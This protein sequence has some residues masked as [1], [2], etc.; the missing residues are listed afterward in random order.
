[1]IVGDSER[2]TAWVVLE[3][4]RDLIRADAIVSITAVPAEG[5]I[6][7]ADWARTHPSKRLHPSRPA[8]V[9]VATSGGV[10]GSVIT[11]PGRNVHQVISELVVLLDRL[12]AEQRPGQ[13]RFLRGRWHNWITRDKKPWTVLE[14]L[15]EPD[16]AYR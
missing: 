4:S 13:V 12:V 10:Q 1:V 7:P 8:R 6:D 5:E 14:E 9:M 3:E 11:C 15:P 2:V 16:W